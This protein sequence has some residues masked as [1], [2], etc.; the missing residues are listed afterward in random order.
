M[1]MMYQ[2]V[3]KIRND[4]Y[5]YYTANLYREDYR[6]FEQK[7]NEGLIKNKKK[8]YEEHVVSKYDAKSLPYIDV[9]SYFSHLSSVHN[10]S[11]RSDKKIGGERG[12]QKKYGDSKVSKS[13]GMISIFSKKN[14]IQSD[15]LSRDRTR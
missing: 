3:E 2:Y 8:V 11:G 4:V 14:S 9:S 10:Y 15:D 1:R 5:R 12:I 7:K 13:Y 6:I